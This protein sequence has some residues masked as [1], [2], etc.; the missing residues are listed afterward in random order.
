MKKAISLMSGILSLLLAFS[1]LSACGGGSDSSDEA[2]SSSESSSSTAEPNDD[3]RLSDSLFADPSLNDRPMVMMHGATTSLI[4]DV[5]ARGYG[6]IVTNVAWGTD[7]LQNSRAFSSLTSC[8]SHALDKGMH[9][10]LYD[11]YGYPSGTA[12]GQTLKD[13]PE[14]EAQGLVPQYKTIEAGSTGRIE[15]LYG[16]SRIVSAYVYEGGS[17]SEMDLSS[18]EDV[19]SLIA[20]DGTFISYTNRSKASR[21]L[22]A[23]MSKPWYENTH[24]MENWYA[25]QRYINML[26]EAPA[27]KFIDI[28][29]E[30]YYD[31][32]SEYFGAGIHAF[33]TDEPALQGSYFEISDRPR[34]VLD[35]P[36][37]NIPLVECLN[38][39]DS[40][41]EKFKSVY[42]YELKPLLGYLYNDDVSVKAKQV[43]MDFYALTG[44]LFRVNYLGQIESWCASKGV[45]SSGHLLLEETLYQ[46]PWF[47]G[48]MIQLLG[49][50]GIPGSDLL[51]S[52]PLGAINAACVVSKMAASAAEFTGKSDTFAE[53]SG[54]FDGTAGDIYDQINAVGV[55][56]CMGINTFASY[57]Y[58]G[59]NHTEDED[60]I[61]STALGRMRYMTTGAAHG[62]K[63]AVYYPYEGASAE[64][65]PSL[66]MWQPA[67]SAKRISD[68]FGD[69]CRTLAGKQVD[70]DLVNYLN[71]AACRVENGALVSP[72]GERYTAVAVPYTTAMRSEAVLKLIEASEAGVQIVLSDFEEI[73]CET[74]KNDVAARFSELAE[75]AYIVTSSN[76]AANYLR[77]NGH[78][79][80]LLNDD[81]AYNVFMSKRENGNYSVFTVVNAYESDKEYGFELEAAGKSLKFYDAVSGR[82]EGIDASFADGKVSFRYTL[83]AN[84][85][86]FF[87]V[88]K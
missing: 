66:N 75:K 65:L 80:T 16:H 54:A 55:Q 28:T 9:V 13:N 57:Y 6:G 46:N 23:Y 79:Y 20:E 51:Y 41:F 82:V 53:I 37:S 56:V 68:S 73:V 32:L 8:V 88:E 40:L 38:Y 69:L 76:G 22:V 1:A 14:Y 42:G 35:T 7:Y 24:S 27:K 67:E 71:L 17:K 12:Y 31:A 4:D 43:R 85:T 44:E 11:E 52:E 2:S 60:K 62:A 10:W 83:P 72:D 78:T 70:Y 86:G 74:G 33:F 26:D 30:K 50:M 84:R 63:V 45:K 21:V 61:F 29:H 49:T 19:S 64:T 3:K 34:Q 25:Q 5:Y 77:R 36:D 47:A 39:S 59:N 18:A 81:S 58:Q 48:D 87:I 15:L